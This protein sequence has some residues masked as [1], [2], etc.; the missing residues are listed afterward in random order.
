MRVNDPAIPLTST[1]AVMVSITM[2]LTAIVTALTALVRVSR[3]MGH[4]DALQAAHTQRLDE[5]RDDLLAQWA[6]SYRSRGEDLAIDRDSHAYAE[7]DALAL[8][9]EGLEIAAQSNALQVLVRNAS[10]GRLDDFARDDGTT[11]KAAVAARRHVSVSGGTS[12]TTS[13]GGA[14]LDRKSVV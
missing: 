4:T 2:S 9:L 14:Y 6:A 13:V 12:T 11:R 1:P 10:G 5:I 7:A 3:W 8:Q